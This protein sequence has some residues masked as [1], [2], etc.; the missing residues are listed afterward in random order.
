MPAVLPAR[1]AETGGSRLAWATEIFLKIKL[2]K[3]AEDVAWWYSAFEL[4]PITGKNKEHNRWRPQAEK[5]RVCGG[6]G[7]EKACRGGGRWS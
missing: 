5:A 7:T 3:R 6:P 1:E 2:S 4:V